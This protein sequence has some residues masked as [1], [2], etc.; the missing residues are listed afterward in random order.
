MNSISINLSNI[1]IT[2]LLIS[3]LF[4]LIIGIIGSLIGSFIW[5]KIKD[6]FKKKKHL[7]KKIK[8]LSHKIK[9]LRERREKLDNRIEE[10]TKKEKA[11]KATILIEEEKN[12][13]TK[14]TLASIYSR[15]P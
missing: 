14:E 2:S 8:K 4:T 11:L 12:R 6:Y 15:K 13:K 9:K 1:D 10:F 7:E 3:I 5:Y